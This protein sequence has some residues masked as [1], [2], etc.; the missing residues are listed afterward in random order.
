MFAINRPEWL[1]GCLC[2]LL[3]SP[4]FFTGF[5]F[6]ILRNLRQTMSKLCFGQTGFDAPYVWMPPS[7]DTTRRAREY[8]I[9]GGSARTNGTLGSMTSRKNTTKQINV[10]KFLIADLSQ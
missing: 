9:W 5:N 2:E 8:G 7:A 3:G 10:T 4:P 6:T 1:G